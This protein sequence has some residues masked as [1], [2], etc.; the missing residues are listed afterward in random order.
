MT[1]Q[2]FLSRN[3]ETLFKPVLT[4]EEYRSFQNEYAGLCLACGETAYNVEPDALRNVCESRSRPKA[5]G[6]EELLLMN[7]LALQ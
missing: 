3:G 1:T 5:Y 4:E 7:L 2:P 6:S